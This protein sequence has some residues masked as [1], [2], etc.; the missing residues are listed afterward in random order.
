MDRVRGGV[1]RGHYQREETRREKSLTKW[2]CFR[3][4]GCA[5]GLT[6]VSIRIEAIVYY[7]NNRINANAGTVS[8]GFTRR[9]EAAPFSHLP[10]RPRTVH[11]DSSFSSSHFHP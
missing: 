8:L 11:K 2:R 6:V 10:P 5:A 4:V 9:H 7:T 1:E 3:D